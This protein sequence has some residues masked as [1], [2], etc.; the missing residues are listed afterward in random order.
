M[1]VR[2]LPVF[3]GCGAMS[4]QGRY[5]IF[6]VIVAVGLALSWGQVGRKAR[7]ALESEPVLLLVTEVPCTPMAS[8]CAATGRDRALVLGPDEQGLRIRHAGIPVSEIIR[9]E[10]LFVG[11]DGRTSGPGNLLPD[12]GAWVVSEV[13]S[14]SGML[15]IRVVRSRDVTVAEFPL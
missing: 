2:A 1:A 4:R 10:A 14:E 6:F 15:R 12:D 13:P 5:W 9:V 11:S 8:P 7:Q 3:A